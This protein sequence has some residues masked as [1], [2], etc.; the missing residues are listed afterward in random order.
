VR[1]A[2]SVERIKERNPMKVLVEPEDTS[3]AALFLAS[4]EARY[5]TGVNLNVNAGNIIV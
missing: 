4:S 5:I 2:A 1:D 3:A